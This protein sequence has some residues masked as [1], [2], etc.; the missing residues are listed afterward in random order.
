MTGKTGPRIWSFLSFIIGLTLLSTTTQALNLN[1]VSP[2]T[3]ES[4]SEDFKQAH[5]VIP[6]IPSANWTCEMFGVRTGLQYEKD[7]FLYKF[8][9]TTKS[10][11]Q[12]DGLSP[13]KSFDLNSKKSEMKGQSG[14]V[15]E[16]IRFQ[17]EKRLV[18]KFVHTRSQKTLA[19]ARCQ[20]LSETLTKRLENTE[21]RNVHD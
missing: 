20:V 2:Q 4:L 8:K 16:F 13:T 10:S 9:P 14:P 18:S 12:N 5:H 17:S 3:K 11:V 6:E 7:V 1:Y 19:F 15:S 21:T